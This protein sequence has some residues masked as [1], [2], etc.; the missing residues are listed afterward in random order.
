MCTI[1]QFMKYIITKDTVTIGQKRKHLSN[2]EI[3]VALLLFIE[4]VLYTVYIQITY[5]HVNIIIMSFPVLL[6]CKSP[7]PRVDINFLFLYVCLCSG[8]VCAV[9]PRRLCFCGSCDYKTC[10]GRRSVSILKMCPVQRKLFLI[11]RA[12]M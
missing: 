1:S 9:R 12:S 8:H 3:I 5:I 4:F 11:R 2:N 10:L 7:C 6:Y